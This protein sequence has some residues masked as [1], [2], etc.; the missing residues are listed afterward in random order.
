MTTPLDNPVRREAEALAFSRPLDIHRWSDDPEVDAWVDAMYARC[1]QGKPSQIERRHLKVVLLDLYAAKLEH[2][3]QRLHMAMG[4]AEYKPKSR[5][6]ALHISKK[7]THVVGLLHD[8]GLI[9]MKLGFKDRRTGLGFYTRIWPS[10]EL[11][12]MFDRCQF[13]ADQ[14]GRASQEVIILRDDKGNLTDYP[15]TAETS[16]M[17]QVIRD[18]DAFLARTLIDIRQLEQP[19]IELG[20]GKV[21]FGPEYQRV[22]RV[23]NRSSFAKGGRFYGGWWQRCPK[24]WRRQIFINDSPTIEQD[25]SSLHVALLYARHGINFYTAADGDA[26]QIDTPPFLSSPEMTRKYAKRLL[27]VA[28]NASTDKK[29]YQAFRNDSRAGGDDFGGGLKDGQLAVMLDALRQRHPLIAHDLGSDAGIDLMYE[30]SRITEHVI[31]SLT[32]RGIPVLTIHDS[33]IVRYGEE[34]ALQEA[35]DQGFSI[36]TGLS[37]IK[38]EVTGVVMGDEASWRTQRLSQEAITRCSGY[39]SRVIDWMASGVGTPS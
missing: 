31:S 6:N 39:R 37:G 21:L 12:A 13:G 35:L 5:Y 18:Y 34:M 10:A 22:R 32:E 9:D 38:T 4:H 7:V 24:E 11:R 14:I 15:E 19:W 2:P 17:R 1:V 27:L 3:D 30:D 28:V 25:Y 26:Y 8:A 33:Y 36:V 23:F 29:A 20:H 16:R